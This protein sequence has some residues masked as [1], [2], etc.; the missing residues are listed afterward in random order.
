MLGFVT[1][2]LGAAVHTLK[3]AV[4]DVIKDLA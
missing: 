3:K 4:D 2:K 1:P